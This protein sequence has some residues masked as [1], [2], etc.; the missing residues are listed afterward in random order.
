MPT[1]PVRSDLEAVVGKANIAQ[2]ADANNDGDDADI[3]ARITWAIEEAASYVLGLLQNRF[4]FANKTTLPS[5]CLRLIAARAC[6]ELYQAPRGLVDGD[7]SF[8][9]INSMA[10][11]VDTKI[12]KYNAGQLRFLDNS[13]EAIQHP[14]IENVT[15]P[16]NQAQ[17]KYALDV[18]GVPYSGYPFS[19]EN[20]NFV[21]DPPNG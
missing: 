3:D 7:S 14:T 10:L 2:W 17:V 15:I 19:V 8:Q 11:R 1:L 6:I 5:A 9:M 20:S 13:N 21:L 12:D 18:G 4:N 16:G